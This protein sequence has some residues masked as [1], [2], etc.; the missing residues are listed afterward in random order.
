MNKTMIKRIYFTLKN[1]F[2]FWNG[3]YAFLNV[4]ILITLGSW[5]ISLNKHGRIK[6]FR[7]CSK[8]GL[9]DSQLKVCGCSG[10]LLMSLSFGFQLCCM[11]F[12]VSKITIW[13][14]FLE[15]W[16]QNSW[17][18]NMFCNFSFVFSCPG[19]AKQTKLTKFANF[20]HKNDMGFAKCTVLGQWDFCGQGKDRKRK[21]QL[22]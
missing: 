18:L 11:V 1:L 3:F 17:G 14:V 10:N 8:E 21:A 22:Y 12:C 20:S 15:N 5:D 6:E 4:Y 19:I 9:D 7:Y 16:R 2:S 13:L